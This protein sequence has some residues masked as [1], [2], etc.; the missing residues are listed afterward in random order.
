MAETNRA[1]FD[2]PEAEAELVAGPYSEYSAL[3]F[4]FFFLSEYGNMIF[5]SI[6]Y[7]NLFLGGWYTF[8]YINFVLFYIKILILCFLFILIRAAFPRVRFDQLLT[9]G[10]KIFLP[11]LLG[12][13]CLN[14]FII[15]YT[16]EF[17]S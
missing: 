6:L 14:S 15:I 5:L 9:L 12:F 13:L 1:P 10:W 17:W 7:T 16:C 4:A 8:G 3:M 2:L 11:I